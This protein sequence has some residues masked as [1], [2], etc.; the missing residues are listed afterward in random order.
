MAQSKKIILTL[1]LFVFSNSIWAQETQFYIDKNK[2]LKDGLSLIDQALYAPA[3]LEFELLKRE[4]AEAADNK[5]YTL[6][7]FADFYYA[8]CAA[9]LN[10]ANTELLFTRFVEAY[11]ETTLRNKAYFELGNFYFRK[12]KTTNAL[13]WYEKVDTRELNNDELIAFKFNLGYSYFKR[14]KLTEAKPLFKSIKDVKHG[15]SE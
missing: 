1:L 12:N 13:E 11:H 3:Q 15:Y 4:V 8:Y 6:N 7:M 5:E 10:Q 2:H 14:K 9:H